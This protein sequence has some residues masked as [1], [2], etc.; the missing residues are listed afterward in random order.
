[1]KITK[2]LQVIGL[3]LS[4]SWSIIFILYGFILTLSDEPMSTTLRLP[5]KFTLKNYYHV[6]F[7]D[8]FPK[9]LA[10]SLIVSFLT[11]TIV[12]F[13]TIW[14]TYT[15]SRFP[16]RATSF[17]YYSLLGF[18]MIPWITFV[19]VIFLIL[20]S[21]NLL[22]TYLGLIL[23]YT[24]WNAPYAVLLLKPFFDDF[25]VELEEA[26]LL[27]GASRSRVLV[28]IVLPLCAPAIGVVFMFVFISS[29]IEFLYAYIL[30]RK[31]AVTLPV[32]LSWYSGAHRVYWKLLLSATMLSVLPI[33]PI[34]YFLQKY[35]AR[36]L[37]FG[38][39]R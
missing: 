3:L 23:V 16:S 37:T 2:L 18:R 19:V 8:G 35:I 17:L 6:I 25:P 39:T 4:V 32:M 10:N 21:M 15:I 13:L 26:A 14:G 29:Y 27:D 20:L 11:S 1:M 30:T 22:D 28:S 12:I 7:V 34:F 24:F 5:T 33:L 9:Y 38:T 36:V 31:D